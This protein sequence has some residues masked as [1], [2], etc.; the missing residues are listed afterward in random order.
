MDEIWVEIKNLPQYSIS[1]IGRIKNNE[2]DTILNPYTTEKGYKR[3]GLSV[4]NKRRNFRVHRLVAEAFIPNLLNKSQVNH[5]DGNKFNNR[6]SNLEWVSDQENHEHAT[7]NQLKVCGENHGCS[8]LTNKDV[9]SIK[10]LLE[11]KIK[12]ITIAQKYNVSAS[13]ISQIKCGILWKHIK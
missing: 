13:V 8:K 5:K 3:I 12:N 4:N 1:N 6:V 11:E 7:V 10:K 2:T 9:L